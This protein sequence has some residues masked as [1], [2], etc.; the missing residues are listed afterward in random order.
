MTAYSSSAFDENLCVSVK[1][2]VAVHMTL[3]A[4]PLVAAVL[5]RFVPLA[6]LAAVLFVVT[7]N[8]SEWREIRT[9]LRLSKTDIAV[10]ITTSALTVV[11]DLTVAVGVGMAFAALLYIYRISEQNRFCCN[12]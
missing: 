6:T 2:S 7:Y 4:I 8:M 9:I 1:H 12:S 3:L 5:A 10:W 11:A